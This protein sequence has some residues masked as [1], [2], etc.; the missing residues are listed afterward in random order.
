M[1]ADNA[2]MGAQR[3][4]DALAHYGL[5]DSLIS[6]FCTRVT[7][8]AGDAAKPHFGL[9]LH[10]YERIAAETDRVVHVA[11]LTDLFLPY[12]RIHP[13]NVGG[14]IHII[15]FT[16][17]TKAKTLCHVSTHTVMGDRT[18]D[19]SLVFRESDLDVGQGFHFLSYQKTKFEAEQLVRAAAE[20]GLNWTIV[21]PGQIFGDS[22]DGSYPMGQDSNVT[23]LF[24]DIFKTVCETGL[25]FRA[26][27]HFDVV[28]VDYVSR[29]I[30]ELGIRSPAIG[31]TF[32]LVNPDV[33]RYTEV[34]E[35]LI[36]QGYPIRLVSQDEY[37]ERL[38]SKTVNWDFTDY[39]SP[40]TSA[41]RWWFK[42]GINFEEGGFTCS[43]FTQEK[44]A[45]R[46]VICPPIDAKL[47]G[48]YLKAGI[49]SG[50]FKTPRKAED[51]SLS[52][53]NREPDPEVEVNA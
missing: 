36:A 19:K 4:L 25:A 37:R 20:Q 5:D 29:G 44:L 33:K 43:A 14:T 45:A 3:L 26:N 22:E 51:A 38:M 31:E 48:T 10:E 46:G 34:V 7:P 2:E 13:V 42:R 6:A 41:F 21:R 40:T 50:F 35:L 12:R 17:G 27:T 28:P 30:L 11:A 52:P 8:V 53:E 16:L 23:G 32:H 9:S 39:K 1:R 24:Y 18:F 47:I 15:D 49:A